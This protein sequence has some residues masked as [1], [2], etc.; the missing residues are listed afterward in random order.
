[1]DLEGDVVASL[2]DLEH[3]PRHNDAGQRLD[4]VLRHLATV[5]TRLSGYEVFAHA[6]LVATEAG[7]HRSGEHAPVLDV[8]ELVPL[9]LQPVVLQR[10]AVG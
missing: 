3:L 8:E 9:G 7:L 4:E 10:H 2:F 1:M 6:A 5:E